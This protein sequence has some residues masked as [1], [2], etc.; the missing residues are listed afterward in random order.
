MKKTGKKIL[1]TLCAVVAITTMLASFS[2]CGILASILQQIGLSE[3]EDT[4]YESAVTIIEEAKQEEYR[5]D[6]IKKYKEAIKEL[7]RI[8][9]YSA[10]AETLAIAKV[11][12]DKLILEE[13]KYCYKF[14]YFE[15]KENLSQMYDQK[16]AE[17]VTVWL[18]FSN[19]FIIYIYDAVVD[20]IK[21]TLK[22]PNSFTDVGSSFSYTIK[23]G[24]KENE[25]IIQNLTYK[26][27]YTAKNSFGG[28]VRDKEEYSFKDLNYEFKSEILSAEEVANVLKYFTFNDM[29]DSLFN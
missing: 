9:D 13:V 20:K 22:D 18:D 23:V 3:S 8:P 12:H 19:N 26:I 24:S 2:A 15:I 7:E 25:I 4:I 21:E 29:C 11:E 5:L 1:S 16:K 14:D 17:S 6:A 10:T 27:D 28:A